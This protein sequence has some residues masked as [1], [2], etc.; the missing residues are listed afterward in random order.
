MSIGFALI[1]KIVNKYCINH[2]AFTAMAQKTYFKSFV[3]EVFEV[4]N[5]GTTKEQDFYYD[6]FPGL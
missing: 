2:H 4:W 6:V 5:Q 1:W 3:N